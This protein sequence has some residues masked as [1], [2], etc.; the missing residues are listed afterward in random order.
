VTRKTPA[1]DHRNETAK[2]VWSELQQSSE[3]ATY[4]AFSES[5]RGPES[6][7]VWRARFKPIGLPEGEDE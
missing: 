3:A 5:L 4:L 2:K 6:L 7:T 1:L